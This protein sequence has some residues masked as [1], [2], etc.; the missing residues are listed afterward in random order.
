MAW[1][2][3]PRL[4][5]LG[6]PFVPKSKCWKARLII[7]FRSWCHTVV[8]HILTDHLFL[9]A[10]IPTFFFKIQLVL[11][12]VMDSELN[13]F[14][15][16]NDNSDS[17]TFRESLRKSIL[18]KTRISSDILYPAERTGRTSLWFD[19]SPILKMRKSVGYLTFK[20][21]ITNRCK[22]VF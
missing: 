5:H 4:S 12:L 19:V 8:F 6:D 15:I 20:L 16:S 11:F 9:G 17:M 1:L 7:N 2:R 14:G 22:N 21:M 10:S 13:F 18:Q 3:W